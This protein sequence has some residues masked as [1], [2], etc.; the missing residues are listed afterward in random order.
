M[1]EIPSLS[2]TR[3]VCHFAPVQLFLNRFECIISALKTI[4]DD[5]TD[6]AEAA[7]AVGYNYKSLLF[8]SF[9]KCLSVFL[10]LQNPHPIVYK[11]SN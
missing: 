3:W 6:R 2:D 8:Y 11:Q 5:S 4:I 1:M 10:A 9:S 7:E